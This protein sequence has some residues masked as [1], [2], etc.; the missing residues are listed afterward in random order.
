[1]NKK[2]TLKIV[3]FAAIFLFVLQS[4]TYIIRTNGDVKDRFVGFYAEKE[5]SI[6]VIMIGSSPVYPC[7][8]GPQIWGEYGITCYPLSSNVQ[9]P[10]AALGLVREAQ[11]TQSPNLYVFEIKQFASDFNED[12]DSMAY[13][14]GVTDNL[15]YSWNRVLTINDM[16]S[17]V[18]DRYTFY[19]D[20]FK[21]HSNWKTMVLPSQ[22]RCFRYEYPDPWKGFVQKAGIHPA[23]YVDYSA[24]E[25][26]MPIPDYNENSLKELLAYLKEHNLNALFV[27][28]PYQLESDVKQKN[29]NYMESMISEAGYEF[30]NLNEH[31]T[32][33][34]FKF[35]EDFYDK[36]VHTNAIGSQKCSTYLAEYILERY[37]IQ[38]KRGDQAYQS[39]DQAYEKWLLGYKESEQQIKDAIR[40]Q[41]Y[42]E[43]QEE[44]EE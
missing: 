15:K 1:M 4:L 32:E 31:L 2:Q 34:D 12:S 25:E 26:Q 22:I 21:Y 18:S 38:D 28:A 33:M 9:R 35:D 10:Q 3:L 29:F 13:T 44:D 8:S 39:W 23:E 40:N 11:K 42:T 41:D 20:I 24:I 37:P 36:G 14:R 7:F 27:L 43:V 17:D 19:F 16:V 6:D 5:N 30:L